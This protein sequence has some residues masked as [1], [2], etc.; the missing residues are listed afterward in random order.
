[1]IEEV[2]IACPYCGETIALLVDTSAGETSYTEDCQV[3]CQPIAVAIRLDHDGSLAG[4]DVHP[5]N[6]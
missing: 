1:M 5:E 6:D 2:A 3:C 4:I